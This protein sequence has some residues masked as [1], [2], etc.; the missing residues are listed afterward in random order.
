MSNFQQKQK[1]HLKKKKLAESSTTWGRLGTTSP[2]R[3]ERTKLHQQ[4]KATGRTEFSVLIASKALS[5]FL[6]VIETLAKL[7]YRYIIYISYKRNINTKI[8]GFWRQ[9]SATYGNLLAFE[10]H[11]TRHFLGIPNHAVT[12]GV[13]MLAHI[14]WNGRKPPGVQWMKIAAKQSSNVQENP[15]LTWHHEILIG[16]QGP[17]NILYWFM[18]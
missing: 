5:P 15:W 17:Y 16:W 3:F 4:P 13:S 7:I 14:A 6:S 2:Y 9:V 8:S 18:K 12:N 1:K 11:P 10:I